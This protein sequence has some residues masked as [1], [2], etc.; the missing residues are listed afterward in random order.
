MDGLKTWETRYGILNKTMVDEFDKQWDYAEKLKEQQL[1]DTDRSFTRES[2]IE[3]Q[4]SFL[5]LFF[6]SRIKML[7]HQ[8]KKKAKKK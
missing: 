3:E 8:K 5:S 2:V 1:D 4:K 6:N 7:R